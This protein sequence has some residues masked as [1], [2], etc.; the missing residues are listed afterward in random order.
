MPEDHPS[1]SPFY[2]LPVLRAAIQATEALL[3][4]L[5]AAE[6]T[7]QRIGE[8]EF[9]EE[10]LILLRTWEARLIDRT[11]NPPPPGE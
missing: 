10:R 11:L 8:R 5:Y 9:Y 7:P 2:S 6:A 3:E 4:A 1:S